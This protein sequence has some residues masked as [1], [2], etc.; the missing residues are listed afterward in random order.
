MFRSTIRN[1]RRTCIVAALPLAVVA[2]FAGVASADPAQ[3]QAPA[4]VVRFVAE[5]VTAAPIAAGL[6]LQEVAT[7]PD[8]QNPDPLA[9]GAAAGALVGAAGSGILGGAA[10]LLGGGIGAIPG[11]IGGA[12]NGAL[13][14]TVIGILVGAISPQ[15]VPQ[16]LP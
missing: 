9:N 3:A 8:A 16:V 13:W 14:G 15:S 6:P 11:A 1:A 7:N 2:G 4:A 5:P 12:I 10:G